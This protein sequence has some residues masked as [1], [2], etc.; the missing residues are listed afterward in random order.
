VYLI[1]ELL[2]GETLADRIAMGPI[3]FRDALELAAQTA[4]GLAAA[5]ERA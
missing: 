1:C 5:H 2:E 3:P 4:E